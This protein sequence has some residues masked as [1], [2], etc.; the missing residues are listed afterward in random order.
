MVDAKMASI[1]VGEVATQAAQ[2]ADLDFSNSHKDTGNRVRSTN[3]AIFE[4]YWVPS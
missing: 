1:S 4:P 2:A 3:V